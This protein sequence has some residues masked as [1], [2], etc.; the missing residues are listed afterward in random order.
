MNVAAILLYRKFIYTKKSGAEIKD[1]EVIKVL[2]NIG[3][4]MKIKSF[5]QTIAII[6]LLNLPLIGQVNNYPSISENKIIIEGETCSWDSNAVHTFSV[7]TANMDGYKY[8]AYYGLDWYRKNPHARKAGLA[9]S[10]DLIHWDKY[11]H[12]PIINKNCRWPTVVISNDV[13]YMFYA[14]YN[15]DNDS[16]IVMLSSKNGID[17]SNKTVIAPYTTGHQNQ[18]P[19]IYFNKPDSTF[20]LFYYSGVERAKVRSD[21]YWNITVKKSKDIAKLQYACPKTVVTSKEVIAAP[22]IAFFNNKY[23]L[24]VE[25]FKIFGTKKKWVTNAFWSDNI[26]HGYERVK[27]NP[28][29]SNSDACAFQYVL[30]KKVYIFYS[31][32]TNISEGHW[33]LRMVEVDN[34]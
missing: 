28:I 20:Y 4:L 26:D 11:K 29:L 8:W 2:K 21:R 22:S 34:E 1:F 24:L 6:A 23:Y 9:R 12:N 15:K 3:N 16:R 5:L 13:F 33:D 25:E 27:N 14:E 18:N 7:V 17:F 10:N 19:F 31:H 32:K 30:D